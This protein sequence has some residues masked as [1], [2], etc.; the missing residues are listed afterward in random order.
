MIG[1]LTSEDYLDLYKNQNIQSEVF[2][3]SQIQPSSLDLSLSNECYEI[4]HSFL[5]PKAKVRDKLKNSSTS[6]LLSSI[7]PID[8]V[9]IVSPLPKV[10][11]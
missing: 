7:V 5:C 11:V 3:F 1:S 2:C 8:I 9:F 4:K 6:T 10:I